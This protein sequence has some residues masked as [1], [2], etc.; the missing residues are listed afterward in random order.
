MIEVW[1][2]IK[3]PMIIGYSS[4][5]TFDYNTETQYFSFHTSFG[6]S[7]GSTDF[8]YCLRQGM[9]AFVGSVNHKINEISSIC[10]RSY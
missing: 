1:S 6:H 8:D 7:G 10:Q 9:E 5:I 2:K 4:C 3:F